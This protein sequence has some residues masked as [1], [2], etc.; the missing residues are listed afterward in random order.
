MSSDMSEDLAAE[1]IL[2]H[3]IFSAL[4]KPLF[5]EPDHVRFLRA[6]SWLCFV[7]RGYIGIMEKKMEG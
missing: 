5:Y 6:F 7:S 4:C 2:A 3:S 1:S